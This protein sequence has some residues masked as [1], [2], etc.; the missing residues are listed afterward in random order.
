MSK[1]LQGHRTKLN[2]TKKS[3]KKVAM[4]WQITVKL[5][6]YMVV[7]KNLIVYSYFCY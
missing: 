7:H 4:I 1:T 6:I 2:K 3:I 5:L